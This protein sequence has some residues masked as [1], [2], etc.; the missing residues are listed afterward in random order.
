MSAFLLFYF[1]CL[2]F[3]VHDYREETRST[4]ASLKHLDV[5]QSETRRPSKVHR[6]RI[7][8]ERQLAYVHCSAAQHTAAYRPE[9]SAPENCRR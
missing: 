2:A 4:H 7:F 8:A 6:V 5:W 9:A 1:H 3:S